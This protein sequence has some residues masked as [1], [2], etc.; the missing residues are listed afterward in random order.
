MHP[1]EPGNSVRKYLCEVLNTA[2]QKTSREKLLLCLN[3]AISNA[4]F[5]EVSDNPVA[6]AGKPAGLK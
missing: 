1:R 2:K 3:Y 4:L 5:G 6:G